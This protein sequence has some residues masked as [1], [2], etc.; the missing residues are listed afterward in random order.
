MAKFK[1]TIVNMELELEGDSRAMGQTVAHVVR[2]V[3]SAVHTPVELP[4]SP[5]P[6]RKARVRP[7]KPQE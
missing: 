4:P 1:I 7:R 3:V 2:G 6:A 5:A